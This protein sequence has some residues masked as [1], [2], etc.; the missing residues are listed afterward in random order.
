MDE[1]GC[2]SGKQVYKSLA[3]AWYFLS[4]MYPRK[5]LAGASIRAYYCPL[6]GKFH[7]GNSGSRGRKRLKRRRFR[8]E[9]RRGPR[10]PRDFPDGPND[11]RQDDDGLA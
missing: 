2:P 11:V 10:S 3:E 1:E 8:H 5:K 6:C 7:N 9:T 4:K